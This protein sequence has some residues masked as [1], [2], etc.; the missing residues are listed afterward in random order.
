M[1]QPDWTLLAR[2]LEGTA[3]PQEQ[4]A[5]E[6]WCQADPAH[7]ALLQRL[8][9]IWRTP[10]IKPGSWDARSAWQKVARRLQLMPMQQDLPPRKPY[11]RSW[12]YGVRVGIVLVLLLVP[13]VVLLWQGRQPA[14]LPAVELPV[15]ENWNTDTGEQKILRLADGTRIWMAPESEVRIQQPYTQYRTLQVQGEVYIEVAAAAG[16]QVL[17]GAVVIRDIGTRFLVRTEQ[18]LGSVQVVVEEGLVAMRGT[19]ATA[20]SLLIGAGMLGQYDGRQQR[21]RLRRL[22]PQELQS[23]LSWRQGK[24]TFQAATLAEVQRQLARWFGVQ[25]VFPSSHRQARLTASFEL[26]QPI[27]EIAEAIGLALRLQP[28]M[29]G[30]LIRF[31]PIQPE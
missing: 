29:Q 21:L 18:P 11:R 16:L 8:E 25:F 15:W 31:Q 19:G 5:V 1:Q 9:L 14:S 27:S 4:E 20:D 30:D 12:S 10:P 22:S 7:Q 6:A 13:L 28:V 17:A 2:Y 26:N 23:Y 24:L 3:T